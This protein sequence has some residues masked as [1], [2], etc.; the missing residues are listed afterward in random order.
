MSLRAARWMMTSCSVALISGVVAVPAPVGAQASALNPRWM[1]WHYEP[2]STGT[3][4][5]VS[6]PTHDELARAVQQLVYAFSQLDVTYPESTFVRP[7][8]YRNIY[9]GCGESPVVAVG[10][11]VVWGADQVVRPAGG[12]GRATLKQHAGHSLGAIWLSINGLPK[13]EDVFSGPPSNLPAG[14][15]V[16]YSPTSTL[17]G[18]PVIDKSTLVVTPPGHPPLYIPVPLERALKLAIA[19]RAA[20]DASEVADAR[21][22]AARYAEGSESAKQYLA[23]M[24]MQQFQEMKKGVL[25]IS[26][27]RVK[28]SKAILELLRTRLAQLTPAT[29][30]APAYVTREAVFSSFIP[31]A[32]SGDGAQAVMTPN[33]EYFDRKVARTVPQLLL[34][35][36]SR[37][38]IAEV[39]QCDTD[40]WQS[41]VVRKVDWAAFAKQLLH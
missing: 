27:S 6:K 15:V 12:V 33:P 26:D 5:Q 32:E 8:G 21:K 35:T 14:S 39:E 9:F 36:L 34:V 13:L 2:Y 28:A 10:D 20:T 18:F 41:S 29:R 7:G 11:V 4:C 16:I 40:G 19:E 31:Q 22:E 24:S 38:C 1:D 17:Q 3:A 37:G 25:D 30:N 23:S